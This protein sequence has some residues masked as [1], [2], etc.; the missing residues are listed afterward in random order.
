MEQEIIQN[1]KKVRLASRKLNALHDEQIAEIICNVANE[2]K[3][4]AKDLIAE[5]A[6]D[7]ARMDSKDSKYDRLLLDEKRINSIADDMEKVAHLPSPLGQILEENILTNGLFLQKKTVPLGVIG[8][9]YESRPNVTLDVFSITLKSGNA[10]ILKGSS[11]AHFSNIFIVNIIKNILQQYDLQ[12]II[13][14]L[15]SERA[16]LIH[17]LQAV[18]E[19]DCII[20]RGSKGLIDYVRANSKVPVIETGAG[21]VH[22][23]FDKEADLEK[24]KNIVTNSKARRVSVCNALDCLVLHESRL[25]DLS[26]LLENL[27]EKYNCEIFADEKSYEFLKNKNSN[28]VKNAKES[29][30]GKEFLAMQLAVKTVENSNEAM[31]FINTFSSKHSEAIV[32]ENQK[33]ADLFTLN[34]DAAV[35]YVNASTAFTDGGE[36]GMG[37]E[38]GISTQKLHARGPMALREMTSYKWIV[39]GDGQIR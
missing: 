39:K 32:T 17:L 9:V 21:V 5:N 1:L 35:V 26:F 28:L 24:G 25:K 33:T 14:L 12:D 11:D 29:D 13:Y 37:A 4:F 31:D 10:T 6:K 2:I 15:P 7:L 27:L 16:S 18:N 19:V 23:Y 3:K 30:F 20:P 38:I 36:F 22:I 34:I 8:I